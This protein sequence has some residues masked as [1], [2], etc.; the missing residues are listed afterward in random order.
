MLCSP[1]LIRESAAIGTFAWCVLVEKGGTVYNKYLLRLCVSRSATSLCPFASLQ[2]TATLWESV[3][4]L[5]SVPH[6]KDHSAVTCVLR[7]V[8]HR[9][10]QIA[11]AA[12]M[13]WADL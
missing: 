1:L 6:C 2:P 10:W 7:R 8:T 9:V 5:R 12:K 13:I 11:A 4:P 3:M